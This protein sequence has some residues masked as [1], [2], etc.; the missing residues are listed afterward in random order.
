[1]KLTSDRVVLEDSDFDTS[2]YDYRWTDTPDGTRLFLLWLR[3]PYKGKPVKQLFV[4]KR[5]DQHRGHHNLLE[6]KPGDEPQ[7]VHGMTF[8]NG[9]TM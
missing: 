9:T 8:V 4:R 1:M 6:L 2:S 7:S 5:Y 3:V